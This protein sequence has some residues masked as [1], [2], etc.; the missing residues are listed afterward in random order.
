MSAYTP[1]FGKKPVYAN[2]EVNGRL[3]HFEKHANDSSSANSRRRLKRRSITRC[4]PTAASI[5]FTA[6]VLETEVARSLLLLEELS[7]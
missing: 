7:F 3:H 6:E 4:L 2:V 5:D 1:A